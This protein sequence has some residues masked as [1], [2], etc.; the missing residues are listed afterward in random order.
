MLPL[1]WMQA[2]QLLLLLLQMEKDPYL[3]LKLDHLPQ[4]LLLSLLGRDLGQPWGLTW[5]PQ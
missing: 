2:H 4:K 5:S 1:L 3:K